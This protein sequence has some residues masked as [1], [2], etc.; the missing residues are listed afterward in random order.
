MNHSNVLKNLWPFVWQ[1]K[2]RLFS[3]IFFLIL[4]KSSLV[5]LPLLLKHI[6][7]RLDINVN[8]EN[9]ILVLPV[10]LLLA[11]GGFRLASS[12]FSELR[13]M[14]FVYITQNTIRQIIHKV[15]I[16]LHNLSLRFHLERKTGGLSRDIERGSRSM[17]FVLSFM[18]FN[19]I[20]N[21]VELL[22]VTIIL[23]LLLNPWF[24]L[25]SAIS[26]LL[27]AG[28]TVI[29]T[30]WR[31]NFVRQRNEM[32]SKANTK[33]ID[34]LLNYETVKY[35]SN[36]TFEANRYDEN[37]SKME[38]AGINSQL[39]LSVLNFG[40]G[41]IIAISITA[42]MFMAA[43]G[44]VLGERTLGDF[45]MVNA[46]LLQLFAP[47]GFLG[48][49]YR[50]VKNGLAD[51]ERM[52]GLLYLNPEVCDKENAHTLEIK[53]AEIKF[54]K[55]SFSYDEKRPILENVS[56]HIPAGKKIAIVGS[57]GAGKSTIVRL[58]F[59]FYDIKQGQILID[60]QDI[61]EITQHSLR[62]SIGI[63]PQDTVLFNDT[64]FYNIQYAKPDASEEEVYKAAKLAH[65][66]E[67]IESL[68]DKYQ[69][70]VGERGLKLSGGEKQRVAIARVI[71]KN[72]PILL[73]DEATSALD[74]KSEQVILAAL[75]EI[76]EKRT[77]LV[78]A[79]RLSTIVD[80]DEIIV[81]E[82]GKVIEKGNH[83]QLLSLNGNYAHMWYLQQQ[84]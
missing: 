61:K 57:S 47:L 75:K 14:I 18:I 5:L 41:A 29:A 49:V 6:V 55:V 7:D 46:Y 58:L 78:I 53:Q 33:A 9:A 22:F 31:N 83:S 17:S 73:L 4:A 23:F 56:F 36:E 21:L 48:F 15:F 25:I 52:F 34:S 51:M 30:D 50:E 32:E 66:S 8:A 64:L 44:V 1:K 81:L 67:F 60:N 16:H 70:M 39:S 72:P 40:Q 65:L 80:A 84:E 76:S 28:F 82:K 27:Y 38:S 68:P 37:L 79:H 19:I 26:I 2:F 63:V 77:T 43:Q 74:S 12:L 71:L 3:A 69:T 45:A 10:I 24:A 59:R 35:F 11:Y 62:Q 20:P 13:D 42:M 54:E